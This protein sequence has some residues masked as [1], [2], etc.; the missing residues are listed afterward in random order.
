MPVPGTGFLLGTH[1]VADP[2]NPDNLLK[3]NADGSINTVDAGPGGGGT[4]SVFGAAFPAD[5]T[6]AGFKDNSGNMAPGNLDATGALKISG[7]VT[8]G[9][10][11]LNITGAASSAA[12]FSNFP[13]TSTIGYRSA[14]VQITTIAAASTI[15]AEESNDGVAW[16]G[17]QL[18]SDTTVRTATPLTA[19][20][21][22]VFPVNA[23]QFRVRQSVY[24]GSGISNI[25]V[26]M[27]AAPVGAGQVAVAQGGAWTV[28]LAAGS[29]VIGHVIT[30]SGST[31]IATQPTA[32]NFNATVVGTGTFAV[33]AAQ[34]GTWTVGLSAGSALIGKVGIDQTTPGT[35]NAV[36]ATNFPTTADT[37]AGNASASTLRVVLAS[38]QPTVPTSPQTC[39]TG[40]ATSVA[41]S[42][43][44]VTV[45][46][47][48]ANRRGAT[49]TN[50]AGGAIL[51]LLNQT[52]GTASLTNYTVPISPGGYYEVPFGYTG[53]LI[54]IWAS[55]SGA[56]RVTEFTA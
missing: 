46:A 41:A 28:S 47:A 23:L 36:S 6:A 14:A 51:Y 48:N 31:T 26:E 30:D 27:R 29:F 18:P 1:W 42:A 19:L 34:T 55:A 52:G 12:V 16:T 33:Q 9:E 11:A 37:N 35:T 17:I 24:G 44:S 32:G 2:N 3:I 43:S 45:L 10:G 7:V 20:D 38:N 40:A 25:N 22:Y 50:D 49:V 13:L 54:G 53:A 21:Q 8:D 15:I 39:S 4:S 5:G 56:G